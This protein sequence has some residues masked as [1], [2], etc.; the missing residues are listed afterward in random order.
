MK[1]GKVCFLKQGNF[2]KTCQLHANKIDSC[3][4]VFHLKSVKSDCALI[5]KNDNTLFIHLFIGSGEIIGKDV[6]AFLTIP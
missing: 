1:P 4:T 5:P 3:F 2:H 6:D